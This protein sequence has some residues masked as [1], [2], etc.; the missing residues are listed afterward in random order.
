MRAHF[1][2]EFIIRDFVPTK[3]VKSYRQVYHKDVLNSLLESD[4]GKW[5]GYPVFWRL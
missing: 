2:N 5:Q 1:V 4:P 3:L